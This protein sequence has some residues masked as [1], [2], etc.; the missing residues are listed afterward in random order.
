MNFI[1]EDAGITLSVKSQKPL[2]YVRMKDD[3]FFDIF[4]TASVSL[5]NICFKVILVKTHT[6]PMTHKV[7]QN[8]RRVWKYFLGISGL[9]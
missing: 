8:S 5:Y 2:V 4:I 9:L 6:T 7:Y 1:L 3:Y